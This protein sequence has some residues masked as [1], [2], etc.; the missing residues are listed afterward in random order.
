MC[1]GRKGSLL[2]IGLSVWGAA[3]LTLDVQRDEPLIDQSGVG[4]V[5]PAAQELPVVHGSGREGECAWEYR[6]VAVLQGVRAELRV[7][8]VV[9]VHPLDFGS[10]VWTV[11]WSVACQLQILVADDLLGD[12]DVWLI[13]WPRIHRYYWTSFRNN[14]K[15]NISCILRGSARFKKKNLSKEMYQEIKY[16]SN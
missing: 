5:D 7:G 6:R 4:I 10:H 1:R 14:N 2:I 13:W 8:Q 16:S 15:R 12:V 11:V 3:E 9:S